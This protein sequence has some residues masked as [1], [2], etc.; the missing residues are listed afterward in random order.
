M[1]LA[2]LMAPA[3]QTVMGQQIHRD[4]QTAADG[5]ILRG[6]QILLAG[7]RAPA[8][9]TLRDGARARAL[10]TQMERAGE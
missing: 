10:P 7:I 4:L 1:A 6:R 3:G 9:L 8:Y 5:Q 2:G